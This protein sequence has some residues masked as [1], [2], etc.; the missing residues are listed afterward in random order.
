MVEPGIEPKTSWLVVRSSDHQATKLVKLLKVKILILASHL[1]SGLKTGLIPS[2]LPMETLFATRSFLIRATYPAHHIILHLATRIMF[3]E[4][5][6][7][8]SMHM[9]QRQF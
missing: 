2:D 4:E 3:D 5:Y 1:C 7:V 8:H 9:W 6:K